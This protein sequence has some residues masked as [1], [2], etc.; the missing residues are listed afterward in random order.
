MTRPVTK[1]YDVVQVKLFKSNY[2]H[3][4]TITCLVVDRH[5]AV[6]KM[7]GLCLLA[8]KLAKKGADIGDA[9]LLNQKVDVLYSDIL[10]GADYYMSVY[11]A[12]KPPVKL[13]GHYLLNTIFGQCIIGK[14]AGST[15][16]VDSTAVSQ[17]SIV[18]VA[19]DGIVEEDFEESVDSLNRNP[20]ISE[21]SQISDNVVCGSIE[22][23]GCIA[24]LSHT[25]KINLS[26]AQTAINSKFHFSSK[27][28][29]VPETVDSNVRTDPVHSP[30]SSNIDIGASVQCP[31]PF[32]NA[33]DLNRFT[34]ESFNFKCDFLNLPKIF[35]FCDIR[36]LTNFILRFFIMMA[37][38]SFPLHHRPKI[39]FDMQNF[40]DRPSPYFREHTG[41]DVQHLCL[42]ECR[43]ADVLLK[44]GMRRWMSLSVMDF[45]LTN[46]LV[47]RQNRENYRHYAKI[48][49]V[50]S[51]LWTGSCCKKTNY[52]VG[53]TSYLMEEKNL[54]PPV[55]L[56][57]AENSLVNDL[58]V[59]WTYGI[60][61]TSQ[62]FEE[63][64]CMDC[65][66]VA[67]TLWNLQLFVG[68]FLLL[69]HSC[70]DVLGPIFK[71]RSQFYFHCRNVIVYIV[72]SALNFTD[73]VYIYNA[74]YLSLWHCRPVLNLFTYLVEELF[75]LLMLLFLVY[76]YIWAECLFVHISVNDIYFRVMFQPDSF[77]GPKVKID[78]VLVH[79]AMILQCGH[80]TIACGMPGQSIGKKFEWVLFMLCT[81]L[82]MYS[83]LLFG[84]GIP[85]KNK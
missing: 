2:Q 49:K 13:L 52:L 12:Q 38:I 83:L 48:S 41:E 79:K 34:F 74:K 62:F 4:S 20:I 42:L 70:T 60:K 3:T 19:T 71:I 25:D 56:D 29:R 14:I 80:R 31:S 11:C 58:G 39:K 35:N 6:C 43:S 47:M 10:L 57:V 15:K 68:G 54:L 81:Y 33:K 63:W 7:T 8:K 1:A 65:D 69:R 59:Y 75:L 44:C 53:Q 64:K 84:T 30:Q 73:H 23:N 40:G 61:N 72:L 85:V 36:F 50:P 32:V 51:F 82:L 66:L 45:G 78:H 76:F 21:E 37:L 9:R 77:E 55:G 27:E 18:H 16:L 22:S 46:L 17:L 5:P 67:Y 24:K 26:V 28:N